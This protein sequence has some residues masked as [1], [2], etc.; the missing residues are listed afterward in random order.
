[1]PLFSVFE[2]SVSVN[3]KYP[4]V[5]FFFQVV[6]CLFTHQKDSHIEQ[7]H[8]MAK[9]Q[10]LIF[11][12]STNLSWTTQALL[13]SKPSAVFELIIYSI[14]WPPQYFFSPVLS[15]TAPVWGHLS[16]ASVSFT[17][18][19][20]EDGPSQNSD[21]HPRKYGSLVQNTAPSH[22]ASRAHSYSF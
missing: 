10:T 11:V 6:Y 5:L 20:R 1:M 19:V 18:R 17:V 3:A 8:T 13:F 16:S 12:T 2:C 14:M 22:S 7:L 21:L 4:Q 9:P 15:W